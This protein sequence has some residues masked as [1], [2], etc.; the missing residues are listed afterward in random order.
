[1]DQED[2]V[3]IQRT[4]VEGEEVASG[5]E[6]E[7]DNTLWVVG[8]GD[9]VAIEDFVRGF[10]EVPKSEKTT[11]PGVEEAT[12]SAIEQPKGK[13]RKLNKICTSLDLVRIIRRQNFLCA[14]SGEPL[15]P[16]NVGAD[17]RVPASKGGGEGPDNI[18]LVLGTINRMKGALDLEEFVYLCRKVATWTDGVES[19][20]QVAPGPEEIGGE[21]DPVKILTEFG[22]IQAAASV[23]KMKGELDSLR[24]TK[25]KH[26]KRKIYDVSQLTEDQRTEIDSLTIQIR[27]LR[28]RRDF[29]KFKTGFST[30]SASRAKDA[31]RQ[32]ASRVGRK[33]EVLSEEG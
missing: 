26:F 2:D 22:Y 11:G 33:Q 19:K 15:T 8:G 32:R 4:S 14:Y 6:A 17:H 16:E 30:A 28:N 10:E 31:E 3:T 27:N 23:V 7:E 18:V 25:F 20:R 21:T 5:R 24:R 29:L 9:V 12:G 1:M 13:S